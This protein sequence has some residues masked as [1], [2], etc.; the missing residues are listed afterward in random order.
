MDENGYVPLVV[1]SRFN[2]V[3]TMTQDISV[4]R[5]S[6]IGSSVVEMK[7]ERI[8]KRGNWSKWIMGKGERE[9]K[10]ERE[11]EREEIYITILILFFS[12]EDIPISTKPVYPYSNN[13]PHNYYSNKPHYYNKITTAGTTTGSNSTKGH[14]TVHTE[15]PATVVTGNITGTDINNNS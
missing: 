15:K 4:I 9:G 1:I 8:R 3:R 2:R 5:E 11:R 7:N 14:Y 10:R 12:D 6:L 13:Y